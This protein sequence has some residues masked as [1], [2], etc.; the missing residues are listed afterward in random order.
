M[1]VADE[2]LVLRGLAGG[3]W[4]GEE[5]KEE[6]EEKEGSRRRVSME[7]KEGM[8]KGEEGGMDGRTC[9]RETARTGL[10][11][12]HNLEHID[13]NA[14]RLRMHKHTQ[15][16][17]NEAHASARKLVPCVNAGH[18]APTVDACVGMRP[19]NACGVH[20]CVYP[21][22][23]CCCAEAA[24]KNRVHHHR[25]ITLK[26]RPIAL[27]HTPHRPQSAT[28]M[29]HTCARVNTCVLRP[30]NQLEE[31][32][33][34]QKQRRGRTGGGAREGR[35][36]GGQEE[37]GGRRRRKWDGGSGGSDG[38]MLSRMTRADLSRSM[39]V[40]VPITT[41][42]MQIKRTQTGGM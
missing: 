10:M 21:R 30:L 7:E 3:R 11:K 23:V 39:R 13:V 32:I 24:A 8:D 1:V 5:E 42:H 36:R 22:T 12:R 17:C 20:A 4:V 40:R 31:S 41:N 34:V 14:H 25:C 26:E 2:R 19:R 6:K 38:R 16:R 18:H 27:S 33:V 29:V 37:E 35:R 9:I 28:P 15:N